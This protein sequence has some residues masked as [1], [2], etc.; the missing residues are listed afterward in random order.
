MRH[1][2][3][4]ANVIFGR[5]GRIATKE[6]ILHLLC[7]KCRPMPILPRC[8]KCRRGLAMRIFRLSVA[9][10]LSVRLSVC[11]SVCQTSELS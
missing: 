3:H 7:T 11:L 1:F 4:A 5:I 2:Y 6:V 10:R 8:M 9:V